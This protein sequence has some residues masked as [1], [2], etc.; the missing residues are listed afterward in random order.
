MDED[1]KKIF[2]NYE[3]DLLSIL[4]FEVRLE[5]CKIAEFNYSFYFFKYLSQLK[6]KYKNFHWFICDSKLV[7]FDLYN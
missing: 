6:N 3:E 1:F 4:S 2:K 5:H 7:V